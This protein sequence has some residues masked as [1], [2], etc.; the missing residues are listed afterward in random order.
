MAKRYYKDN[1]ANR[2][3]GR[4]GKEIPSKAKKEPEKKTTNTPQYQRLLDRTKARKEKKKIVKKAPKYDKKVTVIDSD[5]EEEYGFGVKEK[6]KKVSKPK[7]PSYDEIT[8]DEKKKPAKK[9]GDSDK[10][11]NDEYSKQLMKKRQL[12]K[13]LNEKGKVYRK[14]RKEFGK[15]DPKRPP[16]KPPRG[17]PR[18]KKQPVKDAFEGL[19]DSD[20]DEFFEKP[21]KP[22]QPKPKKKPQ[23]AVVIPPKKREI[24]KPIRTVKKESLDE[25]I[26]RKFEEHKN[27]PISVV[28]KKD[29][30][31]RFVSYAELQGGMERKY[32]SS[33]RLFPSSYL[34]AYVPET[35]FNLTTLGNNLDD[36]LMAVREALPKET[37]KF[38][39]K[40][41]P[42]L[43]LSKA[44]HKNWNP[45][46][47]QFKGPQTPPGPAYIPN[48]PDDMTEEQRIATLNYVPR[49]YPY[50]PSDRDIREANDPNRD[51]STIVVDPRY[52]PPRKGQR[53]F[54]E[55]GGGIKRE[56]KQSGPAPV[57]ASG[58]KHVRQGFYGPDNKPSTPTLEQE[59]IESVVVRTDSDF[60][61][62]I[63]NPGIIEL[64]PYQV[65]APG[66]ANAGFIKNKRA[67]Y[68]KK[69][70]KKP[71]YK[72]RKE[73]LLR[74]ELGTDNVQVRPVRNPR[75]FKG[76]K[77]GD[78]EFIR[79]GEVVDQVKGGVKTRTRDSGDGIVP[80]NDPKIPAKPRQPQTNKAF[81]GGR[82][83]KELSPEQKKEYEK[84]K[85]ANQR[86]NKK[87]AEWNEKYGDIRPKKLIVPPSSG[88]LT[89]GTSSRLTYE[90]GGV[91]DAFNKLG[92]KGKKA[93]PTVI[94]RKEK[95]R[96]GVKPSTAE[97]R[98]AIAAG[99]AKRLATIE[100]REGRLIDV[101]EKAKTEIL[102]NAEL[103]ARRTGK[104]LIQPPKKVK[105]TKLQDKILAAAVRA[106][107]APLK[108][109]GEFA[110]PT[111]VGAMAEHRA[112]IANM[113]QEAL[114]EKG[115]NDAKY[116]KIRQS[117]KEF[118]RRQGQDRAAEILARKGDK[119][120][121]GVKSNQDVASRLA[122]I[123][124]D[125]Y[126]PANVKKGGRVAG[127]DTRYFNMA[128]DEYGNVFNQDGG[129]GGDDLGS[130]GYGVMWQG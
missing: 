115:K 103:K 52:N 49:G 24:K 78:A 39:K 84:I 40:A 102:T 46:R 128:M 32:K 121:I 31:T 69:E 101:K 37:E 41:P 14:A 74:G 83:L 108:N 104:Q 111:P 48:D 18:K 30:P 77:R 98:A 123:E 34:G 88:M 2:K 72:D 50:P 42:R 57:D 93:V 94:A 110:E 97:T 106:G 87:I 114:T 23:R 11:Y 61:G 43:D 65:R 4:A 25:M 45:Y 26:E 92:I 53:G 85:K 113:V 95:V 44:S 56:V 90:P 22:S 7:P 67:D 38:R 107:K 66:R 58:F 79:S 82:K 125:Q 119:R 129:Q 91:Q 63:R 5:D 21:K 54:A 89:K 10:K 70:G 6:G 19:K 1:A 35:E 62:S 112:Q 59:D 51:P 116:Q 9:K 28:G 105:G 127:P 126:K 122:K 120:Q 124:K 109:Q 17:V 36:R 47:T 71:L 118:E 68:A 55:I 64:G 33:G 29:I 130:T 12:N 13:E 81:L 96:K 16:P 73:A 100:R 8:K 15:D 27:S 76:N 117:D 60:E 20:F 75:Y 99:K 80:K 86:Y 3:L